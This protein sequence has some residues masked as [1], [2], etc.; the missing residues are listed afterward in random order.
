MEKGLLTRTAYHEAGHAVMAWRLWRAITSVSIDAEVAGNGFC[1]AQSWA[2]FLVSQGA[3]PH[4]RL[5]QDDIDLALAGPLAE[6]RHARIRGLICPITSK[7]EDISE[8]WELCRHWSGGDGRFLFALSQ[9]AVKR[10]LQRPKTWRAVEA[11]AAK[12]LALYCLSG[13]TVYNIIDAAY[14]PHRNLLRTA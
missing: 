14:G 6:W 1:A 9:L 7:S 5:I 10:W 2:L 4:D 13:D 12:L 11:L 8:A 3:K